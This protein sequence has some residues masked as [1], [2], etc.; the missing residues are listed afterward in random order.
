[1]AIVCSDSNVGRIL[2]ITAVDAIYPVVAS[3][4]DALEALGV[5]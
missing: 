2:E 1:M 4:E 5:G 3:T